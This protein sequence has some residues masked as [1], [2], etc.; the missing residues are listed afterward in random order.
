M[1]RAT[2]RR[3]FVK[4][5][6]AG[7]ATLMA[8]PALLTLPEPAAYASGE[9][10]ES[11]FILGWDG[12][13][14]N[15]VLPMLKK[16]QLPNLQRF[17]D[18]RGGYR[19]P[20]QLVGYTLTVTS[21]SQVFTGLTHDQT[22]MVG[23]FKHDLTTGMVIQ[24]VPKPFK[25]EY[26]P[27]KRIFRG[28]SVWYEEIPFEHSIL[29]PI[30]QLGYRV[31]TFASKGFFTEE[32]GNPFR[33]ICASIHRCDFHDPNLTPELP[34]K[35]ATMD[36]TYLPSL[37]A[38]AFKF[39]SNHERHFI[40]L[41]LNPDIY[42]HKHGE[43]SSRYRQEF[44]RCDVVLGQLLDRTDPETTRII[45]ISDHGFDPGEFTH[46]NA[47]DAWMV[48]DLP[49]HPLFVYQQKQKA[50]GT[51]RDVACTILD[52]FGVPLSTMPLQMRGI[53]MLT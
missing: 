5:L 53:S 7:A 17:M 24:R 13:G 2:T 4:Q 35:E 34:A 22:S 6:A 45:V 10:P 20:L 8:S 29:K 38:K 12:A 42:G 43:A 51:M 3:D 19:C 46:A 31:G 32:D 41:H 37:R 48:T 30:K 47:P 44:R 23:N 15:N 50:F 21:W 27:A 14:L 1:S 16:G 49:I 9:S 26:K 18:A 52:H 28:N 25:P 33:D 36:D 39:A 40:F 11:M